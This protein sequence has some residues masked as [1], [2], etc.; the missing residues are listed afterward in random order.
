MKTPV[1]RPGSVAS[2][3]TNE[4]GTA[5]VEELSRVGVFS[6]RQSE[7]AARYAGMQDRAIDKGWTDIEAGDLIEGSRRRIEEFL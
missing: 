2:S 6:E 3:V 1:G 4:E 5:I 7:R